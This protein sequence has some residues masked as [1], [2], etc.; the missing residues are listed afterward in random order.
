MKDVIDAY[1]RK[2]VEWDDSQQ[3][4]TNERYGYLLSGILPKEVG[5][6]IADAINEKLS[7]LKQ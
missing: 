6:F 5:E 2:G 4:I 3:E 7:Q 1:L